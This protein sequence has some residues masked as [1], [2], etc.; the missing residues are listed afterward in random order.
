MAWTRSPSARI[1]GVQKV[2]GEPVAAG[3]SDRA[4]KTRT[5]LLAVSVVA[6][7]LVRLGLHVNRDA[8]VFGF[9]LSGLTDRMVRVGLAVWIVY[10]L[11]HF[12]WMAWE[13]FAEWRLRLTGTRVASITVGTFGGE[14]SDYPSDPQQSTLA[15]WWRG[16]AQKIGNLTALMSGLEPRLTSQ[17][18][19]IR[20]ACQTN[21]A[22]NVAS[23]TMPLGDIR[24]AAQQLRQQIQQTEKTLSSLRIP[25]SLDRFERAYAH[26]LKS[27]N[28]RWLVLDVLLPLIVAVAALFVL[29][30]Q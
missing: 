12:A 20:E 3:L 1:E 22:I 5:Q 27:Q 28:I 9:S 21:N 2:L 25:A 8:T 17:E 4:W 15:N 11:A 26:F 18:A 30:R 23:A 24:S 29:V 10:L 6:I 16:E 7:A 19:A 13:G 14:E